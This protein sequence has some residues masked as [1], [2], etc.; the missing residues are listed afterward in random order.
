MELEKALQSVFSPVCREFYRKER[1]SKMLGFFALCLEPAALP[2]L[3]KDFD[4]NYEKM[5]C[6]GGETGGFARV[7]H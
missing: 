6:C 2:F 7:D 3:E 5:A 4:M 1:L